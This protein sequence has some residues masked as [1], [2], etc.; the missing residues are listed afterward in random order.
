MEAMNQDLILV[1]YPQ[2]GE[3]PGEPAA[4]PAIYWLVFVFIEC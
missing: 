2:I 1:A 3:S 4:K